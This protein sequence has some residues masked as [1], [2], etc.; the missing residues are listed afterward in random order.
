MADQAV[1]ERLQ[2]VLDH[3]EAAGHVSVESGVPDRQLALVSRRE[4]EP[5][6]LVGQGHHQVAANARL[7]V[8]GRELRARAAGLELARRLRAR[9]GLAATVL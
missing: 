9:V 7:N 3:G 2:N 4:D 8:L 6:R 1:Y 5:A